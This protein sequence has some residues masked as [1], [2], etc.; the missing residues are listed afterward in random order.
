MVAENQKKTVSGHMK[1][2]NSVFI[3]AVLLNAATAICLHIVD[4]S[5]Y[6]VTAELGSCDKDPVTRKA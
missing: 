2:W 1:I 5:F 6:P 4:S 3:N